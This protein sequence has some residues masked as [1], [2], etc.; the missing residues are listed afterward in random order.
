[1]PNPAT[2]KHP[3]LQPLADRWSPRAFADKPVE[4]DKLKQLF[5]ALRWA[6][7]SYN[8]QPWRFLLATKDQPEEYQRIL[9][10]LLEAN[11]AWA[12]TAP[13]IGLTITSLNFLK[14]GKPNRCHEHDLGLAM[15]NLSAQA[16]A[17]GL[18]VHQMAGVELDKVTKEFAVPEGFKPFS[19]F[20]IGYEG[21][22]DQLPE[23]WMIDGDKAPRS[24]KPL[25]ETVFTG[26]F[27]KAS[28]LVSD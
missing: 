24:R 15:G 27:G 14:N 17:L 22:P 26:S 3:I 11:Q 13:V 21:D 28:P 7:S 6:A 16:A 2:P 5:E 4:P 18:C 23:Q 25:G 1:M 8:E 9:S 20:T 12:K 19:A 10:C